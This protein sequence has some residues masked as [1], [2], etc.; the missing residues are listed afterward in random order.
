MG[1]EDQ[2][3]SQADL[4]Y[5]LKQFRPDAANASIPVIS[6]NGGRNDPSSPGNEAMLDVETIVGIAYPIKTSF[7]SYGN[8][9]DNSQGV[10]CVD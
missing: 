10:S 9:S 4:T 8:L 3:F 2:F 7:Y 5:F 1:Y 6:V